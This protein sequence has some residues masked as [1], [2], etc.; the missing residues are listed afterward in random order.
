MALTQAT[1][2]IKIRTVCFKDLLLE[3]LTILNQMT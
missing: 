3:E 1:G 2:I